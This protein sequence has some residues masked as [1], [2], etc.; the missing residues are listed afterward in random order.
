[1]RWRIIAIVSLGVN[2]LMG[3]VWLMAGRGAL[4][5]RGP[6]LASAAQGAATQAKTNL[7]VRRQIFSWQEL[8]AADYPT[9][10]ANLR[11]I[12]CPEQTIR[13]IIIA[14]VNA[15]YARKR[16]TE[17]VSPEQ[18]WWRTSPD[19]NMVQAAAQKARE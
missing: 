19:T 7:V 11:Q 12:G 8:E 6:S 3:A 15:L 13:D 9:Y 17:V 16:A 1:M 14:D 2:L 10:I 5:A 18:Q 4:P